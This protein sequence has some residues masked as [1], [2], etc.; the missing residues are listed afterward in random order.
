MK[1]SESERRFIESFIESCGGECRMLEFDEEFLK[2]EIRKGFFIDA[3][4]KSMWAAIMETLARISAV[5]EKYDIQW[6]AAYGTLLGA[7]REEGFVP[8][9]D[10]MDIWVMRKGYNKLMEVLP[11]ELPE[12]FVLQSCF[13]DVGY[14][15]FHSC[16]NNGSG[17]SIRP[18]WLKEFH[19][20]PFT[21][22]I[23]IFPLDYLPRDEKERNFQMSLFQMTGQAAMTV[24]EMGRSDLSEERRQALFAEIMEVKETI[25]DFCSYRFNEQYLYDEKWSM[26]SADFWKCANYITMM[27][28]EEDA[29]YIVEY[30]DYEKFGKKFKKEWFVDTYSATFENLML[31]IPSGYDEVLKA[32]YG[33]YLVPSRNGGLHEYPFYMRQLREL[34]RVVKQREE[35]ADPTGEHR[36]PEP[37]KIFP[38]N[39]EELIEGKKVVLF[40]DGI[41]I[42][43][44]FGMDALRKLEEVLRLFYEN[45]DKIALW[46]RPQLQIRTALGLLSQELVDYYDK[47]VAKYREEAWGI[48]DI[49][50]ED[51]LAIEKSQAYYGE[52]N[53]TVKNLEGKIPIMIEAIV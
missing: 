49:S 17:V 7:I 25:E 50:L 42:Y 5:C 2:P 23:D 4:M 15:Q 32:I 44:E 28:D 53:S 9:D 19:G 30:L 51:E 13:T 21:I 48:Y 45:R 24:K 38:A 27:Y 43:T 26:V 36:R 52:M 47:I 1:S 14:D 16:L 8:W 39:W 46:W 33:N 12:G 6:Y 22:A 11:K 29:D 20:C 40:E 34:R 10:D 18:E 37:Q 41:P 31:P 3:T 35:E